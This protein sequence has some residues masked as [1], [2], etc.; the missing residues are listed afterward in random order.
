MPIH[1]SKLEEIGNAI[2]E[3]VIAKY[4]VPDYII[5]DQDST[6][7]SSL[8]KYLFEKLDI[9]I[10]SHHIIINHNRKN[11]ELNLYQLF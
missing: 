9:K 6:F 10:K 1:Q 11:M 4:C 5:M 3:N 7:M 2:I 8:V